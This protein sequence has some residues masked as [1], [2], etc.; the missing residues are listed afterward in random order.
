MKTKITTN[1]AMTMII[2]KIPLSV[3]TMNEVVE[4][5]P[6]KWEATENTLDDEIVLQLQDENI[7]ISEIL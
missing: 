4:L 5:P 6:N 7:F 3:R 1:T 2:R